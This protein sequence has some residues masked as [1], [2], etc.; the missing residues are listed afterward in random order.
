MQNAINQALRLVH[1]IEKTQAGNTALDRQQL[2][3]V[4]EICAK[5][6][7][8]LPAPSHLVSKERAQF[9]RKAVCSTCAAKVRPSKMQPVVDS[10][11]AALW[12]YRSKLLAYIE[13]HGGGGQ[14]TISV[15][16]L[17]P[18]E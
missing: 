16:D 15:H 12:A 8:G 1:E 7:F 11:R 3:T 13:E 2:A 4:V 9:L 6:I 10:V 5:P 18:T 17:R 14:E